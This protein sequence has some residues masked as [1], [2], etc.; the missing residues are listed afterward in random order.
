MWALAII[1]LEFLRNQ[2]AVYS[3]WGTSKDEFEREERLAKPINIFVKPR[4]MVK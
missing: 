2:E 4:R 3:Q 1:T